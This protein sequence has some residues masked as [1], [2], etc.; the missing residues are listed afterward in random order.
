L[1]RRFLEKFAIQTLQ[2]SRRAE[3]S[4]RVASAD[5]LGKGF[6][7]DREGDDPDGLFLGIKRMGSQK[8]GVRLWIFG[9]L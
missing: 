4:E 6:R 1:S 7:R 3:E 5:G 2:R 9:F 8:N